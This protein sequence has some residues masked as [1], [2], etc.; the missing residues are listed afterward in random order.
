M[1]DIQY[2][3]PCAG[4]ASIALALLFEEYASTVHVNDLSR[5]VYAIWHEVLNNTEAF[6]T[7][8]ERAE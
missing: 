6:C 8:I 5:L 3:E 4:G 2:V 7:K 1:H